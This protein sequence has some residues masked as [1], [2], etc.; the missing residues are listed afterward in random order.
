MIL[1]RILYEEL[2]KEMGQNMENVDGFTSFEISAKKEDFV[3]PPS[4][5]FF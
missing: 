2:H 3:L 1:G 4:L 5:C